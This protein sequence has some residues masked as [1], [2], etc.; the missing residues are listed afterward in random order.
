M[1]LVSRVCVSSPLAVALFVAL[2]QGCG[3]S[4]EASL[5]AE[6]AS[7]ASS[8]VDGGN[9]AAAVGAAGTGG[10]TAGATAGAG[11]AAVPVVNATAPGRYVTASTSVGSGPCAGVTLASLVDKIHA[12]TPTLADVTVVYNPA[13]A[14]GDGSF[15]YPYVRSDGGFDI[16][17][18]RGSGDCPA[19]C[20]DNTYEYFATDATCTPVEIGHYH[21]TWGAQ[22]CLTVD[23]AALWNHP[24]APDPLTVCGQDNTPRDLHGMYLLHASGQRTP[25]TATASKAAGI[26]ATVMVLVEQ[27]AQDL[28][29]GFVTFSGTGHALVDGVRLPARFQRRRFD[30]SAQSSNAPNTC[31]REQSV[32]SR[33]D[34]ENYQPGG[35]EVMESGNDACAVC[36]GSMSLTLTSTTLTQAP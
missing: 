22:N 5:A 35:I 16:V 10:P 3:S 28:A 7:D 29:A 32:T 12:V 27:N 34:F 6:H 30:A 21:A 19:G 31:P 9:D 24:P 18:Q 2:V 33:Y 20:T 8:P 4:G 11:D 25:C 36:K 23:G 1:L 13:A 17:F 14:G 26:D 15:I